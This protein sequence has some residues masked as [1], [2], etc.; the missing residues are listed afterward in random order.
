MT[1]RLCSMRL[2]S[3]LRFQP[4]RPASNSPHQ[5]PK[6]HVENTDTRGAKIAQNEPL[7]IDPLENAI[8]RERSSPKKFAPLLGKPVVR[9]MIDRDRIV[10]LIRCRE[11]FPRCRTRSSQGS[12]TRSGH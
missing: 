10:T 11:N 8:R 5:V 6:E 7:P 12:I 1:R 2:S 3:R 4:S 9:L